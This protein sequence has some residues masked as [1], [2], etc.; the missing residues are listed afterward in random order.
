VA[1]SGFRF[2]YGI[3]RDVLLQ[4]V[5][6]ARRRVLHERLATTRRDRRSDP[7]EPRAMPLVR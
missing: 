7:N 1:G 4:T 2:R 6:P 3:V 5:S